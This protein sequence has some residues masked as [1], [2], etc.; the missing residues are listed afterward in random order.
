MPILDDDD[1]LLP[2]QLGMRIA[3]PREG[4]VLTWS[5]GKAVAVSGRAFVQG[6]TESQVG[7]VECRI[8]EGE[9]VSAYDGDPDFSVDWGTELELP[10]P[11]RQQITVRARTAGERGSWRSFTRDIEV[12]LAVDLTAQGTSRRDYLADLLQLTEFRIR[13]EDDE[14]I[15]GPRLAATFHQ[16]FD[17]LTDRDVAGE[18]TRRVSRARIAV[19]ALRGFLGDD[20]DEVAST[21]PRAAYRALLRHAGAS[22]EELR[23]AR[24][25]DPDARA[26]LGDRLGVDVRE[27]AD[28]P[29]D[30]LLMP[31]DELGEPELE[32]LFGLRD[33]RRDPLEASPP[34]APR[35]LR[36][37]RGRLRRRWVREDHDGASRDG[38]RTR[39]PI[40][41]PDL[42]DEAD[43]ADPVEGSPAFDLLEAR[44]RW[45]ADELARIREAREA[46]DDPAEALATVVEEFL[47]ADL[48]AL[49]GAH[50]EGVDIRDQLAERRLDLVTFERLLAVRRLAGAGTVLDVEWSDV[51]AICVQ[52]RKRRE[53]YE[54]WREEEREEGVTLSPDHFRPREAGAPALELPRWRATGSVR[55]GWE[56]RLTARVDQWR[57]AERGLAQAVASAEAAA[58]PLLRDALVEAAAD[59]DEGIDAN[60]LSQRLAVP[61]GDEGQERVAR[62]QQAVET[63]QT[64]LF[65]VRTHRF[66]ALAP[67]RDDAPFGWRL[68]VDEDEGAGQEP[69]YRADEFDREWQ[70]MGAYRNWRAAM[71]VFMHPENYLKPS[72]RERPADDAGGRS[73]FWKLMDALRG[74]RRLSRGQA[75]RLAAAYLAELRGRAEEDTGDPDDGTEPIG[76]EPDEDERP[77][78]SLDEEIEDD[79]GSIHDD[80]AE[81]PETE[82][83]ELTEQRSHAQ[84]RR[85]RGRL[86]EMFDERDV[87]DPADAPEHL[88]ELFFF[89]P[90][91]IALTLQRSGEFLAALDW[92]RT[93]YAYDLPEGERRIYPGLVLEWDRE[94]TAHRTKDWLLGGLNPHRLVNVT[95]QRPGAYTRFTLLALVR[96]FLDYADEEFAK[97]TAESLSRAR[98]LYGT[99]L[100][101]LDLPELAPTPADDEDHPFPPNEEPETLRARVRSHLDKLRQGRNIAGLER[102]TRDDEGETGLSARDGRLELDQT[103]AHE[104]TPYRYRALI[105]RAKQL[106]DLAQQIE[107]SYLSALAQR[108]AEAYT[109]LQAEQD[110]ELSRATVELQDLRLSEAS[111]TIDLANAQ[112]E[113][114][115]IREDHYQ[116]L[117]SEGKLDSEIEMIHGYQSAAYAEKEA[118]AWSSIGGMVQGAVSGAITGAALGPAGAAAGFVGGG[119]LGGGLAMATGD[120]A[121]QRGIEAST[122][123]QIASVRAN[124]E[125]R[126]EEWE[127]Q[128]A[129]AGQDIGIGEQQVR[130]ALDQLAVVE[131]ERDIARLEVQH[132]EADAQFLSE[133]FT[134]AELYEW[135]SGVLGRVYAWFLQQAAATARLAHRQLAFERQAA[136][137]SVIQADYWRAPSEEATGPLPGGGEQDADRRGL[138]GSARLLGDIFRLDQHAFE[139]RQRQLEVSQTFSLSRLAP[140]E[141]QLFRET[142]VLQF[143]TPMESFDRAFPGHYLRLVRRVRASVVALVPPVEGIRATLTNSGLSRVVTGREGFDRTVVRRLPER[144]AFTSPTDATGVLELRPDDDLLR[145]FETMG[146]DTSWQ[147][148]LPRAAN[149]IDF[150]TVSDV[151]LTIEYTALHSDAHRQQ[152]VQRLGRSV[153]ADRAFSVRERFPDQ[154]YD[155]HNP[156][157]AEDPM[158]ARL[159]VRRTDFLPN[160]E[161][162]RVR[163]ILLYAVRDDD[164]DFEI[165]VEALRLRDGDDVVEGGRARSTDGIISTRRGHASSWSPLLGQPPAGRWEL[166]LADDDGLRDRLADEDLRDLLFVV[167]Y[168]GRAPAWPA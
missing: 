8:G 73:A 65:G 76:D 156:A 51:D 22:Y 30:A 165:E 82:R 70:W 72:L 39:E 140:Y 38:G 83:F 69:P 57:V 105:D 92:F 138:T 1:E 129:L 74:D 79:L 62:V 31:L 135:M 53:R 88:Q 80:I 49:E 109:L 146:V 142:G 14:P 111:S 32:E 52:A 46:H 136:P 6:P 163:Q 127:V 60:W 47:D 117:I 161:E 71:S 118:G 89:A 116:E 108:D 133:Q 87:E 61:V 148:E 155:L 7:Q 115:R 4:Q 131:L 152:V 66:A 54:T 24:G 16:P 50:E 130:V 106:A 150:R 99:A 128:R 126:K 125:R 119:L 18:A 114:A 158:T 91:Q 9:F 77:V 143:D 20:A 28:D 141:F 37:R 56:R 98:G 94:P 59:E 44:R 48:D 132:A 21:Y 3:Q 58:L 27:D 68:D 11:G 85:L 33:T 19:E 93:V 75:R 45:V 102:R 25:A 167:S 97:E 122:S 110:I 103:A 90:L 164:A 2:G 157:Q 95:S 124:F 134:N 43:L 113:H 23:L 5:E 40:V 149:P 10:G 101:L 159:D 67:D 121:T 26:A 154:W 81:D 120:R 84:L 162:L 139:T 153:V 42:L 29:L 168:E 12:A 86:A 13:A 35:L 104:A 78:D 55:R 36:W 166:A 144:I 34:E 107:A 137:P 147:L 41:E 160:L 96:C 123:A 112:V 145:P 17:R 63:L 15:D 100:G 151:L 64:V